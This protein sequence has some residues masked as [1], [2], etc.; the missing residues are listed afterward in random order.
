MVYHLVEE[1]IFETYMKTLF[2]AVERFVIIYSSNSNTREEHQASH[3]RHRVFTEW[4]DTNMPEWGLMK[5]IPNKYPG[6]ASG[7]HADFYLYEKRRRDE[8]TIPGET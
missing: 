2:G 6:D 8:R 1:E 3:V 7:A 4:V 5:H